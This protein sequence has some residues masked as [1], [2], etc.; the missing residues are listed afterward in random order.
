MTCS[1]RDSGFLLLEALAALAVLAVASLFLAR[2]LAEALHAAHSGAN[3]LREASLRQ[4]AADPQTLSAA[5]GAWRLI[6]PAPAPFPAA[7]GSRTVPPC[8]RRLTSF[9]GDFVWIEVRCG[10]RVHDLPAAPAA[11]GLLVPR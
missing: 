2:A 9:A 7:R 4:L 8:W 10:V 11:P 3:R 5:D 1:Q 6:D